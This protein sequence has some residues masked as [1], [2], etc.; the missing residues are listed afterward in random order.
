MKSRDG[1]S[2]H[3]KT[4]YGSWLVRFFSED[5]EVRN[6]N[7]KT[8]TERDSLERAIKRRE[9]LDYWFPAAS[10]NLSKCDVGTFK[11]LAEKWLD[12]SIMVREI[13]QSC[14]MNYRCHLKHHILPVIGDRFLKDL[15]LLAIEE[16]AATLKEKRPLT[17]SYVAVRQ[18]RLQN[19]M[20]DE[21]YEDDDF[22][23]GAYRR[24]ILTV[25]CMVTKFGFERGFLA[26]NPFRQFKLPECPEQPYDYWRLDDEDAFFKWLE[27]GAY[28]C[29]EVC[30]PHSV[31]LGRPE[32]FMKKFKTRNVEDLYDTVL[33]ALRSG[34]RKG[35]I[36]ALTTRDINFAKNYVIVRRSYSE[37]EKRVKTTTKGKTFRIIEMNEDMRKILIKRSERAKLDTDLLFNTKTWAIKNFSKYC[38]KAGVREIHFHSLRHTCLTN[39]ANGYGMD[40]PLPLPQVQKIAGHKDV[41]TTMRYVHVDGIENTGSRQWSRELRRNLQEAKASLV[42]ESILA[43]LPTVL[44][45]AQQIKSRHL[46]LVNFPSS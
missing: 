8:K 14:M 38:A 23:S 11:A 13:S 42:S 24:E 20:A 17:S 43:S 10:A 46:K 29:K 3:Y 27:N 28:V 5:G 21:F 22:L 1:K 12:H 30:R 4:K 36:G 39:L 25:A 26:V 35:E 6:K 45:V 34:L 41:G 40:S 7:C 9:D 18:K 33:F 31:R 19:Q 2:T 37:K 15:N 32:K 16:V 44:P